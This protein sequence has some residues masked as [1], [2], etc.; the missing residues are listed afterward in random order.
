MRIEAGGESGDCGLSGWWMDA[1]VIIRGKGI[2]FT[3]GIQSLV[4][5]GVV[6][7]GGRMMIVLGRG[8]AMFF[9]IR[10][11]SSYSVHAQVLVP[12]VRPHALTGITPKNV[13]F[14]FALGG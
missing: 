3:V 13:S 5:N 6:S 9:Q 10:F 1:G 11:Y 7:L 8:T 2:A 4:N 12:L 14:R